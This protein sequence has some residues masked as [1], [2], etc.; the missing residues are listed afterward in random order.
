MKAHVSGAFCNSNRHAVVGRLNIGRQLRVEL[1]VIEIGVQ[2]GQDGAS[3][4]EA[5]ALSGGMPD[6]SQE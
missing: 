2:V 3:R 6:R 4:L 1:L 5:A